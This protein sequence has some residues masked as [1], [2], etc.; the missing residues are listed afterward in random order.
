MI[1]LKLM[2][3]LLLFFVALSTAMPFLAAQSDDNSG[4]KHV[5]IYHP[6]YQNQAM[7]LRDYHNQRGTRTSI[8]STDYIKDTYPYF[9]PR[10]S[11]LDYSQGAMSP[12]PSVSPKG[13]FCSIDPHFIEYWDD[14][15]TD[16]RKKT[17][18]EPLDV[19]S[20]IQNIGKVGMNN[21]GVP[22][23][24]VTLFG[25]P[26]EIPNFMEDDNLDTL[27]GDNGIDAYYSLQNFEDLIPD[28][29]VSRMS[30]IPTKDDQ[31]KRL[32]I[33]PSTGVVYASG[34]TFFSGEKIG[35]YLYL[36]RTVEQVVDNTAT[37][38][39]GQT[40]FILSPLADTLAYNP[41][42]PYAVNGNMSL[43]EEGYVHSAI[44]PGC[45]LALYSNNT[46]VG[47][48]EIERYDDVYQYTEEAAL[49]DININNPIGLL[50]VNNI[51][52]QGATLIRATTVQGAALTWP[53][54]MDTSQ[55][56]VIL[57]QGT[58]NFYIPV[59]WNRTVDGYEINT[60]GYTN[61][62]ETISSGVK[63]SL[64]VVNPGDYYSSSITHARLIAP[65]QYFG[66]RGF[67]SDGM[68][69]IAW[70]MVRKVTSFGEYV[71]VQGKG[72]FFSNITM[73]GA[74]SYPGN[75]ATHGEHALLHSLNYTDP[76][77]NNG[78]YSLF[79]G[80]HV[81]KVF[82]TNDGAMYDPIAGTRLRFSVNNSQTT[83]Q[84][85]LRK[86]TGVGLVLIENNEWEKKI[87]MTPGYLLDSYSSVPSNVNPELPVYLVNSA[88]V[89]LV[90]DISSVVANIWN[91]T[92]D[93]D[94][95][96]RDQPG[97][98]AE[99]VA[100]MPTPGDSRFFGAIG[101]LGFSRP[102][103]SSSYQRNM[104]FGRMRSGVYDL[105]GAYEYP[106]NLNQFL[107][108]SATL[109][110]SQAN[111]PNLGDMWKVAIQDFIT[112]YIEDIMASDP[113]DQANKVTA[114]DE[115]WAFLSHWVS[116]GDAAVN[117]P[118]HD[119]WP[120]GTSIPAE[121]SRPSLTLEG[122]PH[123]DREEVPV[124]DVAD[125]GTTSVKIRINNNNTA[126]KFRVTLVNLM[127]YLPLEEYENRI[128]KHTVWS[129]DPLKTDMKSRFYTRI[130]DKS[131]SG[132]YTT[133]SFDFSPTYSVNTS[134]IITATG[135]GA[136][137][138]KVE[139][140]ERAR[141]SHPQQWTKES[142][143]F[144]KVTNKF[145]SSS[146]PDHVQFLLVNNTD[147]APYH[148]SYYDTDYSEPNPDIRYY[149]D[150]LD[151][152]QYTKGTFSYVSSAGTSSTFQ[153]DSA[154]MMISKRI[155]AGDKIR[156]RPST[157]VQF[158]P[159]FRV[160]S[161]GTNTITITH[162]GYSA[163]SF[164]SGYS[165]IPYLVQRTFTEGHAVI[166]YTSED[167]KY[168]LSGSQVT[169]VVDED[170]SGADWSR[171][172]DIVR[173]SANYPTEGDWFRFTDEGAYVKIRNVSVTATGLTLT[174]DATEYPSESLN[175][176][177]THRGTSQGPVEQYPVFGEGNSGNVRGSYAIYPGTGTEPKYLYKTW[178]THNWN[179]S[180]KKGQGLHGDLKEDILRYFTTEN[181]QHRAVVW[182]N[183]TAYFSYD[184]W[185]PS[186]DHP[187]YRSTI[188][189]RDGD[190]SAETYVHTWPN[191]YYDVNATVSLI[192][193]SDGLYTEQSPNL[194][195]SY[196]Y[197]PEW[198]N[199]PS[200]TETRLIKSYGSIYPDYLFSKK[201]RSLLLGLM[202][203][204]GRV[205]MG[206]Q[207]VLPVD[208]ELNPTQDALY[209]KMGVTLQVPF[210][211]KTDIISA[212]NEQIS[213][214]LDSTK[215]SGGKIMHSTYSNQR[216]LLDGEASF[217][218][219]FNTG[220]G[221]HNDYSL[222]VFYYSDSSGNRPSPKPNDLI[223]ALKC[224]GGPDNLPYASVFLGFD[225]GS[226][227][228]SGSKN[229]LESSNSFFGRRLIMK[230]SLDW[231]RDPTRTVP[232]YRLTVSATISRAQDNVY[233]ASL[234]FTGT[235]NLKTIFGWMYNSD[236]FTFTAD[237]GTIYDT[238][239][240]TWKLVSQGTFSNTMAPKLSVI[241]ESDSKVAV[242]TPGNSPGTD[243]LS[244]T[245]PDG[246][247]QTIEIDVLK[248]PL[249]A[250]LATDTR[251]VDGK[252]MAYYYDSTGAIKLA[253]IPFEVIGGEGPGSYIYTVN[254]IPSLAK[255]DY[256]KTS[257]N[258]HITNAVYRLPSESAATSITEKT[259]VS[260]N[261][262]SGSEQKNVSFSLLAPVRYTQDTLNT[263]LRS[264]V[265]GIQA[266]VSAIEGD[267]EEPYEFSVDS[268]SNGNVTLTG[269]N[270][271]SISVVAQSGSNNPNSPGKAVISVESFGVKA[272]QTATVN[273][274]GAPAI[275][276]KSGNSWY[277]STG[278]TIIRPLTSGNAELSLRAIGGLKDTTWSVLSR[279]TST[280]S[281]QHI[282][283]STELT[284]NADNDGASSFVTTYDDTKAVV[285]LKGADTDFSSI[286]IQIESGGAITVAEFNFD[287]TTE[288]QD[289]DST[290]DDTGGGGDDDDDDDDDDPTVLP[291]VG[292][293]SGRPVERVDNTGGCL[294]R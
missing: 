187:G 158:T 24:H 125:N 80:F 118:K 155:F 10:L 68:D 93:D 172:N 246:T 258:G 78:Q 178:H 260:I 174:L 54:T 110:Y 220:L 1:R 273:L 31:F 173:G 111:S 143:V 42:Y 39:G 77:M 224:C 112:W 247:T 139:A 232:G 219:F 3:G 168:K 271:G 86:T 216:G 280:L 276:Y 288:I 221:I 82:E 11:P 105:N 130:I 198:E 47:V 215:L 61:V 279:S 13:A 157:S 159:W 107:T 205:L 152:Y 51:E 27:W 188:L 248:R 60:L 261:I 268:V 124:F 170:E 109:F 181:G 89:N 192:P 146:L 46:L 194:S 95:F 163:S 204:G 267:V 66:N 164:N 278:E 294:F 175:V 121:V 81:S 9:F 284:G 156:F 115:S 12:W 237:K 211:G 250:G 73:L 28:I 286:T 154:S 228:I 241:D 190:N 132:D 148:L 151:N 7:A 208:T 36:T 240:Y 137:M 2:K 79:N 136:Y 203:A 230:K 57:I 52:E 29:A 251:I 62:R 266:T 218:G 53:T 49:L 270:A 33:S 292:A 74:N 140:L 171:N 252:A 92:W 225:L 214:G 17:I 100:M 102:R 76:D 242:Y 145:D 282:A 91:N 264:V 22:V 16:F 106:L 210:T 186:S 25:N 272:Q 147:R 101:G 293:I 197:D 88:S 55:R 217:M 85:I 257:V 244:I 131:S 239:E 37:S 43:F 189:D 48:T 277:T 8:V 199:N 32:A 72:D 64:H 254:S 113:E 213:E 117:F 4:A 83:R 144:F 236:V 207:F 133:V 269:Q 290:D 70:D 19:L 6:R 259:D 138:V 108:H 122:S 67:F 75:W 255:S 245:A 238:T 249:T 262:L 149:Y 34:D 176:Y 123:Y 87:K 165:K 5:I 195:P 222:P 45:L 233:Q 96:D 201:D 274:Y 98:L 71:F 161:V 120:A 20:Y 99:L 185:H 119:R 291:D 59:S 275:S 15:R 191:A 18:F 104:H 94:D 226:V 234:P 166:P 97:L 200:P 141:A 63:I 56:Y 182:A 116:L 90:P 134:G 162:P 206:G 256:I 183:E 212:S 84:E 196:M 229:Q 231:L 202:S 169:I 287:S 243:I 128:G 193:A 235:V 180:N 150:A 142:R 177:H 285:V 167:G 103:W 129:I 69:T 50:Q 65:D 58:K 35:E 38:V 209:A 114:A 14:R 281:I 40:V 283:N 223:A 227:S 184:G 41:N 26:L 21:E 160:K 126:T 153:A 265:G 179:F 44:F 23:S 263:D 30:V 127:L 289:D 135:P 253:A